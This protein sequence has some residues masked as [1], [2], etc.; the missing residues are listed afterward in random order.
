[1]LVSRHTSALAN[2]DI[3]VNTATAITAPVPYPA[4]AP[5]RPCTHPYNRNR[6]GPA[7]RGCSYQDQLE[8]IQ[9]READAAATQLKKQE[10]AAVAEEYKAACVPGMLPGV[11]WTETI[12]PDVG[13]PALLTMRSQAPPLATMSAPFRLS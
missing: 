7:R 1:M 5:V 10:A 9:A 3:A 2:T 12:H 8:I 4:I 6:R 13:C 11:M